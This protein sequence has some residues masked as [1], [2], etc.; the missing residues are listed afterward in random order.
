MRD[1]VFVW[2]A[3]TFVMGIV[4]VTPDSF[5]GDGLGAD[6]ARTVAK[7]RHFEAEGADIVD[8]GAES[9]RPGAPELDPQE[10]L[11]RLQPHL[12]AA[13]AA[14]TLPISVDT[15]HAAVAQRALELGADLINDISGLVRDPE[16]STVV[17]KSGAAVV[18][19]HNQ[20][21]RPVRT[22]AWEL[23]ERL[24][25]ILCA[26]E[27]A[28]IPLGR[29]IW[30]PGFG[31]G[32]DASQNLEILRVLPQFWDAGLPILT[33]VSRKSTIGRVV[34]GDPQDRLEGTAAL[35]SLSIAAGADLVRVHDVREMVRVAKMTDAVVRGW[36]EK[37]V[38]S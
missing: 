38:A 11:R 37:E 1:T 10:E 5:S 34:G 19:M 32:W 20:R 4:N 12:E 2:G 26:A 31:F 28:G 14:T 22:V 13:R 18:A 36:D 17:A 24:D 25:A 7:V 30:D 3:R 29:V 9:S 15:Y 35:V 8:I 33:G 6:V 23:R 27:R 16:M 21:G